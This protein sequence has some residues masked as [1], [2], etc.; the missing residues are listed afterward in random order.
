MVY[1]PLSPHTHRKQ[2]SVEKNRVDIRAC[3]ISQSLI[4]DAILSCL[5]FFISEQ[6]FLF[7]VIFNLIYIFVTNFLITCC[8]QMRVLIVC[9]FFQEKL[10]K[11]REKL[12]VVVF[13]RSLTTADATGA[14]MTLRLPFATWLMRLR[15]MMTVFAVIGR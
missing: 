13:L 1:T 5:P 14:V 10:K 3:V 6:D 4:G 15:L 9:F 8:A 2:S 7:L 11:N 12:T